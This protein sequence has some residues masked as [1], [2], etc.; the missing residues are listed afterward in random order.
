MN[1]NTK[2]RYKI[3]L[4]Y[5]GCNKIGFQ[6]QDGYESLGDPKSMQMIIESALYT[7]TKER[8]TLIAS[9]R[10]DK[11]VHA[12]FMTCHFD[13]SYKAELFKLEN[14]LNFFLK[15][16]N[17][18]I[19]KIEYVDQNFHARFDSKSREYIYRI[20]TLHDSKAGMFQNKIWFIGKDL[21]IDK[22]NQAS[23]L[24]IGTKDFSSFRAEGCQAKSPITTIH[25]A[26]IKEYN[27][28]FP[29][30]RF[31]I[32]ATA[33][34]YHMVRNIMGTLVLVGTN[35]ITINDFEN[36]INA[37]DRSKAGPTAKSCGLYFYKSNY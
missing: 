35:I 21:N 20:S 3:I 11:G 13:L 37:K 5:D 34:L 15:K 7:I 14:S 18:A 27:D 10:T 6:R 2:Q 36:I 33:F 8:A 23:L 12:I 9:G 30:I 24:L 25:S 29:E 32:K 16:H 22:M 28:F 17:A 26:N 1:N 19:I 31:H 4:Q